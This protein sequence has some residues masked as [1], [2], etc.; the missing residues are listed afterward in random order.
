MATLLSNQWLSSY[1]V[2]DNAQHKPDKYV[3]DWG[4]QNRN[5]VMG[6]KH[7]ISFSK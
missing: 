3:C 1:P 2:M 4:V 5:P 6:S 7:L